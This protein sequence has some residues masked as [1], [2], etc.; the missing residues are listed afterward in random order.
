LLAPVWSLKSTDNCFQFRANYQCM[1]FESFP[2]KLDSTIRKKVLSVQNLILNWSKSL[3]LMHES[4]G[5]I[6]RVNQNS[7]L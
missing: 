2:G 3:I 4:R 6:L 5:E 1:N 7:N